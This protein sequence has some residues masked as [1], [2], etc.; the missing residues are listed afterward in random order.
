MRS[1]HVV[2]LSPLSRPVRL[3]PRRREA[4]EGPRRGL[5]LARGVHRRSGRYPRPLLAARRPSALRTLPWRARPYVTS[6][7]N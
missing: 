5:A 7:A 2:A 6:A 1:A 3:R 4:R